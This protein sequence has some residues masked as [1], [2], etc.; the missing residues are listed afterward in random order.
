[1]NT[2]HFSGGSRYLIG[3]GSVEHQCFSLGQT[4]I[5]VGWSNCVWLHHWAACAV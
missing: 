2:L 3:T 1:M 4:G 5:S